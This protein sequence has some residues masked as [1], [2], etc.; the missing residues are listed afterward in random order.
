M[1]N[2]IIYTIPLTPPLSSVFLN[3]TYTN[4]IHQPFTIL[5]A[6]IWQTADVNLF[7]YGVA[8]RL[9]R[10]HGIVMT[11]MLDLTSSSVAYKTKGSDII[12]KTITYNT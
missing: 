3:Y 7:A 6:Y 5:Y 8:A 9:L 10:C 1:C 11:A 4:H 2:T 12:T